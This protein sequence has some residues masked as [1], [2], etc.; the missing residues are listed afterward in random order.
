MVG[1]LLDDPLSLIIG[2]E[3]VH[4]DEWHVNFVLLIQMLKECAL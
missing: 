3:G 1:V 2:V 4:E